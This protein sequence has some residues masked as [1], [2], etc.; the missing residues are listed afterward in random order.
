MRLL[1]PF[2]GFRGLSGSL[3]VRDDLDTSGAHPNL[4][5]GSNGEAGGLEPP[6]SPFGNR[7]LQAHGLTGVALFFCGGPSWRQW[8]RPETACPTRK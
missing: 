5:P 3:D 2:G 6:P 1:A 4:V 7:K 8:P